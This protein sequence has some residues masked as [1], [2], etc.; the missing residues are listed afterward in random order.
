MPRPLSWLGWA[1]LL[2]MGV[3]CNRPSEPPTTTPTHVDYASAETSTGIMVIE[4]PGST[5]ASVHFQGPHELRLTLKAP[6]VACSMPVGD[7]HIRVQAPGFENTTVK[8]ALEADKT[9]SMT[10][11]LTPKETV[12]L[13]QTETA[14]VIF[15]GQRLPTKTRLLVDDYVSNPSRG[16]TRTYVGKKLVKRRQ[17]DGAAVADLSELQWK[18]RAAVIHGFSAPS[19]DDRV[20]TLVESREGRHFLIAADGHVVQLVDLVDQVPALNRFHDRTTVHIGLQIPLSLEPGS[21]HVRDAVIQGKPTTMPAFTD[22]QHEALRMLLAELNHHLPRIRLEVPTLNGT[23]RR[24]ALTWP[25]LFRGVLARY[26]ADKHSMLPGPGLDFNRVLPSSNTGAKQEGEANE[27]AL[28]VKA[29]DPNSQLLLS[30]P[31]SAKIMGTGTVVVCRPLSGT[32]VAASRRHGETTIVSQVSVNKSNLTRMTLQAFK[33]GSLTIQTSRKVT[34]RIKGPDGFTRDLSGPTTLSDL[35]EGTY[36][37]RVTN[38]RTSTLEE[39]WA[40]RVKGGQE[41]TFHLPRVGPES[42]TIQIAGR[43][44]LLEPGVRAIS[45]EDSKGYSFYRAQKQIGDTERLYEPRRN[46]RGEAITTLEAM[47]R[48][49]R[50]VVLHADVLDDIETAFHVLHSKGLSSHFGIDFDG[51]IYQMLDPVDVAYGAGEVNPISIQIDLNNRMHNLMKEPKAPPYPVQNKR[52]RKMR[53]PDYKRPLSDPMTINGKSVRSYG[54]TE[55]QYTAL[56]ALLRVLSGALEHIDLVFPTGPQ[57]T[58]FSWQD[59]YEDFEGVVGHFHL[60]PRRWDPGPG[61][62]WSRLNDGFLGH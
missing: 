36:R 28:W 42:S 26:H 46:S 9:Q 13:G 58:T 39:R 56:F 14:G 30:G 31:E 34:L 19:L 11:F 8:V 59:T 5:D 41:S 22:A 33:T 37:I 16:L 17:Y 48:S 61:F 3:G 43:H 10:V 51:T 27:N 20:K 53:L 32:W 18:V 1:A 57:E 45:F 24:D 40:I 2:W 44:H 29:P 7:W 55:A 23:V 4:V 60:T 54:Y 35:R 38:P 12:G 50:L 6:A 52:Y 15:D 21:A 49:V 62:E 47:Q 25:R